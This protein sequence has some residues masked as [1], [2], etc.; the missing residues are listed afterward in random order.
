MVPPPFVRFLN[1]CFYKLDTRCSGGPKDLEPNTFDFINLG[2]LFAE[3]KLKAK[4]T[5][6]AAWKNH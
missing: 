2:K 3:R 6:L 5:I 4:L 1:E